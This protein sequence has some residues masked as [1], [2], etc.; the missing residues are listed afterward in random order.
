MLV[1]PYSHDQPDH[2]ARLRRLGIARSIP[3]ERYNAAAA[4][5]EIAALLRDKSY[6]DSAAD[7]GV[8]VRSETGLARACDLLEEL[9]RKSYPEPLAYQQQEP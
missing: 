1:V 7:V 4:T 8:R 5:R 9:L 3:R 2:A 6:A